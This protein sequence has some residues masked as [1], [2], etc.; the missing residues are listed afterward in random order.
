[1]EIV[2]TSR[3]SKPRNEYE[4]NQAI[5]KNKADDIM[6]KYYEISGIDRESENVIMNAPTSIS[7]SDIESIDKVVH[8]PLMFPITEFE[9]KFL[10]Y[11]NPHTGEIATPDM[12]I[13]F[14]RLMRETQYTS[15]RY[16]IIESIRI[17]NNTSILK[18]LY[19]NKLLDVLRV[20]LSECLEKIDILYDFAENVLTFLRNVWISSSILEDHAYNVGKVIVR[21]T[22][23]GDSKLSG[24]ASGIKQKWLDAIQVSDDSDISSEQNDEMEEADTED[25]N[26]LRTRHRAYRVDSN[27]EYESELA[28]RKRARIRPKKNGKYSESVSVNV[29]IISKLLTRSLPSNQYHQSNNRSNI[30]ISVSVDPTTHSHIIITPFHRTH[31][32]NTEPLPL[33][34]NSHFL[35]LIL[36]FHQIYLKMKTPFTLPNTVDVEPDLR[37]RVVQAEDIQLAVRYLNTGYYGEW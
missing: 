14:I 22:K 17:M 27:P 25:P 24:I 10:T 20:W 32:S 12:V 13:P 29:P 30:L 7:Q 19:K 9:K 5:D 2:G 35:Q 31:H 26:V 28:R 18:Y 11:L 15:D 36:I 3:K 4:G 21:F 8:D 6:K 33:Y 37:G 23:L 34:Q 1:M 16:L